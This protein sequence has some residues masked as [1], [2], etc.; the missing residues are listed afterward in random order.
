M[1]AVCWHTY[2]MAERH[3]LWS[4]CEDGRSYC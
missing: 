1:F 2:Q 3:L 4:R